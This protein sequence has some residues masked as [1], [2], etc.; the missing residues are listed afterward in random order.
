[1]RHPSS[2]ARLA[3]LGLF[4]LLAACAGAPELQVDDDPLAAAAPGEALDEAEAEAE[5][6]ALF[7]ANPKILAGVGGVDLLR[8]RVDER[9][10]AHVRYTQ[11]HEGLPVFGGE[12]IVHLSPAGALFRVTDGLVRDLQ[13]DVKPT[14]DAAAA[15][16]AAQALLPDGAADVTAPTA[17]L[18]VLR[19]AGAD[20]LT[21]TVRQYV[22]LADGGLSQPLLFVDARTGEAVDGWDDIKTAALRD[23][24]KVTYTMAGGTRFNRATV[25]DSSDADLNTTHTAIGQ[26]LAFL[27][28][29]GRDSYNGAGA[30]VKSYGHYSRNYVNAYWD[31]SKLVFGDGDG[32]YSDY[33]G[34]LDVAAHELGHAVTDYEANLTYSYESGALNE[35]ASDIFA[36]AVEAHVD[37]GVTASTWDIGEDCWLAA[38]ALRYMDQPSADGSSYDY[39]PAR[40][41]GSSDNGGVHWNSGIANHYF[42]L[43]SQG[44]QHHTA[45][46]RSGNTVTGLGIGPSYAIWYSALSNYMTASTNFAGARTA[47]E[48]A[49]AALGYTSTQCSSVSYA[50][51]EVGVGSNPA[52]SGGGGGGGGDGGDT[53][54][55]TSCPSGWGEVTGNL[56]GT[57][58]SDSYTYSAG[59]GSHQLALYGPSGAVDFDLYLAKANSRGRYSNVATSTASGS[60]ESI[61]YSGTS[62]NYRIQVSSYAG[63]GDYQLCYLLP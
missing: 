52:G 62:G 4:G 44:G 41:T 12:M 42:Y 54:T 27:A 48:S 51:Y 35:A 15:I 56:T 5:V 63:A 14:L 28:T 33:L 57:G 11:T 6:E 3:P 34:V 40:Y 45:A 38:P 29:L 21:W 53:G 50:W 8:T 60:T 17:E 9:G 7:A 46:Y 18:V 49:C 13:V 39:Y 25:G 43:L 32:V 61:T 22:E 2:A 30:Q 47:N 24:D 55:G 10:F 36:A 37:G 26:S 20:H 23:A 31:G 59:S 16:A 1:M 58:D 19:K